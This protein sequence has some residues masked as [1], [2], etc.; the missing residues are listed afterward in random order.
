MIM[1]FLLSLAV[2]DIGDISS[3]PAPPIPIELQT[4]FE[5]FLKDPASAQI[6]ITID[7][8]GSGAGSQSRVICGRFNAKNSYGGYVGY[9]KFVY[10][11][12]SKTL[13]SEDTAVRATGTDS[14]QEIMS[15]DPDTKD[16]LDVLSA[17][18]DALIVEI[19]HAFDQCEG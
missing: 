13:Y 11:S 8:S 3:P 14:L 18:G 17:K 12:D 6:R 16:E 2:G 5:D 15:H 9:K 10:L 4:K 19:H 1:L 7:K